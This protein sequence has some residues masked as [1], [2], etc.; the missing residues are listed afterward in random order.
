MND[1]MKEIDHSFL[2]SFRR[3]I[4]FLACY[5]VHWILTYSF[6][7]FRMMER[8]KVAVDVS[9]A[10]T[11]LGLDKELGVFGCCY[12]SCR[13]LD[14]PDDPYSF[15]YLARKASSVENGSYCD[16]L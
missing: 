11:Y 4:H 9:I 13:T 10:Y 5:L 6:R 3:G 2:L 12:Y 14:H 8:L 1:Q 16:V 15:S 7:T